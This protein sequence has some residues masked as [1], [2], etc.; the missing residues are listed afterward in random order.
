VITV[1]YAAGFDDSI[2]YIMDQ[3]PTYE[4]IERALRSTKN[5]Y[6]ETAIREL[7]ANA[8]IHQDLTLTG[9]G[10]MVEIFDNRIEITNPGG[11][12]VSPDRFIDSAPQSR[13][14][15]LARTMRTLQIC[16][17]RGSGWDK[18]GF[19]IEFHQ[20]PAPL[21]QTTDRSTRVVV[22]SSRGLDKMDKGDRIRAVY[23]HACLR[24]VSQQPMTNATVRARFRLPD[25]S[26]ATASRL[27][28][29]ATTV[30]VIVPYDPTVGTRAMRYVPSWA[31]PARTQDDHDPQTP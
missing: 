8:L 16:E 12:L 3:V 10:P 1:G 4:E 2:R 14:E 20:L 7:V 17:E 31:A 28:R 23:L 30:G 11:P 15:K 5:G 24:Y 21:V 25:T 26:S 19:E 27:I 6:P 18:V 22:F 13:N 9:T 29:E